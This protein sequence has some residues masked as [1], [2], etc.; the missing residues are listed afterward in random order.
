[1]LCVQAR[2]S[3]A[4]GGICERLQKAG[5][6]YARLAIASRGLINRLMRVI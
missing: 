3:Q 2:N 1:M 6:Y 5:L 4:A